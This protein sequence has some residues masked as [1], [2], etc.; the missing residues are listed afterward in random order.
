MTKEIVEEA[1][2]EA[3]AASPPAI[4]KAAGSAG[5]A[6]GEPQA[7]NAPI[8][9]EPAASEAATLPAMGMVLE[10]AVG[11][12]PTLVVLP[13][14]VA[15]KMVKPAASTVATPSPAKL[16]KPGST[17]EAGVSS[18]VQRK[19]KWLEPD[20]EEVGVPSF[21]PE[22][23]E[24]RPDVPEELAASIGSAGEQMRYFCS[25]IRKVGLKAEPGFKA[26]S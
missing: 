17:S 5:T 2:K 4:E 23:S 7:A 1:T 13:K 25:A 14:P 9:E 18:S 16:V 22:A 12:M 6:L 26:S 24:F 19:R 10:P 15:T 21:F 3:G 8:M 11:G 20:L